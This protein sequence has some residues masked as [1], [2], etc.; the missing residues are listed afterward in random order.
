M[1]GRR[2]SRAL[3]TPV[4]F[5]G[6]TLLT[7]LVLLAVFAPILWHGRA[8]A[9]DTHNILAGPSTEHLIGTDALGRDNFFRVLVAT[10]LTVQ[11]GVCATAISLVVGILL[12]AAPILLGR[13][14]GRLISALVNIL[15]AF[16]ALLLVLFLAVVFGIGAT[17]A[18]LAVGLAGAP[19]FG[20]LCQTLIAGV[21]GHDYVAA[22]RIAGVSRIRILL[23]HVLPNIAEPLIV[24]A[25]IGAGSVLLAFA[26]LSFLGLGVQSPSYDWGRLMQD[27]LSAV[28]TQ[29]LAALAPGVAVILAGLA[30][31]LTGEAFARGFGISPA[32]DL[33]LAPATDRGAV[34]EPVTG[35]LADTGAGAQSDAVLEV[36]DLTVSFPGAAGP[37]RPVRGVSFRVERGQALGVVGESGSGK[38]LTALAVAQLVEAPGRVEAHRL[39]FDGSDLLDERDHRSPG[40]LLGQSLA[41]VFQD[42]MTS[43]NPGHRMGPQLAEG[44]RQHQGLSRRA[45]L[46]RAVDRLHA[47]RLSEPERRARQYPFE[48][49]GGMRQRAMIAMGLMGSPQLII[50]DEPTTALDVTVQQ[51]VLDLISEVRTTDGTALLMISHDVSVVAQVCDRVMVMYAGRVVE[52]LSASDLWTGARHPYSRALVA[53]VP[54]MATDIDAPLASIP[55]RPVDPAEVPLGCAYAARCPLA[56]DHCRSSDPELVS[57]TDGSAVACWHADETRSFDPTV[58]IGEVAG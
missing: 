23:R 51:Q 41:V 12:G 58:T 44:A 30:F 6:L 21:E 18:A 56:D 1:T 11:L 22:A 25:T 53:A 5:V 47:V 15:V 8:D 34:A 48:F 33:P 38:S 3:R 42:P 35:H 52:E 16:P 40:R 27:G 31:N 28:Y 57:D 20:R 49:S 43:F 45:A 17:G 55:G 2:W 37:I 24:N 29:P 10:R 50:A 14:A 7:V 19:V 26:G 39:V 13:R 46:T 4:G 54:D 9:V 32:S 36:R